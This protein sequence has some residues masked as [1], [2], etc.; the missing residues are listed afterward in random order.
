LPH[1]AI[2][3]SY[4]APSHLLVAGIT[5]L[6]GV[7]MTIAYVRAREPL[8]VRQLRALHTGSTNDYAAFAT[9]GLLA[10]VVVLLG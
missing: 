3:F 1:L 5:A 7:G 2:S 4:G 6:L 8:P 9:A 10:V